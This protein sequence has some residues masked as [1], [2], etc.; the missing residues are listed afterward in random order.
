MSA[1]RVGITTAIVSVNWS[2]DLIRSALSQELFEGHP[3][4]SSDTQLLCCNTFE[5]ASRP[6]SPTRDNTSSTTTGSIIGGVHTSHDK[7]QCF[8][9]I[10]NVVQGAHPN[11]TVYIGDSITDVLALLEADVGV[12]MCPTEKNSVLLPALWN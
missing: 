8:R 10:R 4:L 2:R 1:E 7:R 9:L 11:L 3:L 5:F 12:L 6:A